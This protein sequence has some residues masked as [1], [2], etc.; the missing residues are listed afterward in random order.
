MKYKVWV[1]GVPFSGKSYFAASFP[2]TY[3]INTDGN[4]Q[5]YKN[6]SGGTQVSN[7]EEFVKALEN[8]D[9]EK[10]DTLVI[11]VLDHVY[12]MCREK[13]LQENGIE[14]ESDYESTGAYGKGWT[15][16]REQFWYLISKI[17]NIPTNLVLISHDAEKEEK[18]KLGTTKTIYA[19]ATIPKA[20]ISKLSGIMHFVG[21]CYKDDEKYVISFGGNDNE[22]S[23]YRLPIKETIIENSYEKF[24][25]N[26]EE[27]K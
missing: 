14:H 16:L 23:G 21:H 15:L 8:F 3:V 20:I 7:Y 26:I 9:S 19:P 2:N 1:Y 10:Y 11:D 12:D 17:R 22:L 25:E 27:R 18:G 13:F 6:A 24:V 5:F 4:L